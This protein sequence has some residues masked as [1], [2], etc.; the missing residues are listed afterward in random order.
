[1]SSMIRITYETSFPMRGATRGSLQLHQILP[2]PH[3]MNVTSD[4]Q[5]MKRHFQCAEQAKSPSNLTKYCA[6][7]E[8]LRSTFQRRIPELL[9]PIERR[10]DDNPTTHPT[11]SDDIRRYPTRSDDKIVISHP[12]LR[13]PYSSHLGDDFVL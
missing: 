8:I 7:H 3:K 5:H 6:C 13:G 12:P 4:L 1:M 2:L 10:F 11:R 9:L